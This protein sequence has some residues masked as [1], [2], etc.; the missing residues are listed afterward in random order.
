MLKRGTWLLLLSAIALT[1]GVLLLE[2]RS[3]DRPE[4]TASNELATEKLFP[5]E[6]EDIEQFSVVRASAEGQEDSDDEALSFVK[7]DDG[8][9]EMTVPERLPDKAIAQ[10]G[11]IAFLLSQVTTTNAKPVA[12]EPDAD[13]NSDAT[14][15]ATESL[16][17]FGLADPTATLSLTANGSDYQLLIGGLDFAGNQRYVQAIESPSAEPADSIEMPTEMPTASSIYLISSDIITAIERPTEDWLLQDEATTNEATEETA[18]EETATENPPPGEP[19]E[20]ASERE[21]NERENGQ[22]ATEENP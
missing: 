22:S 17:P 7:G 1:G 11:A 13:S 12:I 18:T 10:N 2:N 20:D 9:W 15:D 6:E 4:D 16:E 14:A 3:G 21:N 8:N 5:F 19:V